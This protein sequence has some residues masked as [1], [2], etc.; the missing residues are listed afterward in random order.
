MVYPFDTHV[1]FLSQF[2]IVQL[3]INTFFLILSYSKTSKK[4]VLFVSIYDVYTFI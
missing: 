1:T 4:Y 3:H 2:L